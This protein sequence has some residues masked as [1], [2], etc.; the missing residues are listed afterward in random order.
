MATTDNT[1]NTT[2]QPQSQQPEEKKPHDIKHEVH[3]W[4]YNVMHGIVLVLSLLLIVYISYDTFEQIPFLSNH[5]Y[6]LFQFWVCVVFLADFFI[7]LFLAQDKKTYFKHNWF[8]LLVSIPYL[9]IINQYNIHFS[10]QVLYYLRF[11][12]LLRGSYALA[13]VLGAISRNRAVSL[14]WQYATIL[15]ALVYCL[16]LIFFY[17]EKG[18]NHYVK[19]FWDALYWAAMN[20][21]TVGCYFPPVTITGKVISVIL[22]ISG[23]LMLPLFTVYITDIVRK[24]NNTKPQ[25]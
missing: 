25:Y 22:P 24:H 11:V 14:L 10:A 7:S 16:A 17:E 1:P 6:M 9:N 13:M 15:A 2:P 4:I 5:H 23:M 19:T 8:F 20:M 21:T 18:V 12:P 3:K